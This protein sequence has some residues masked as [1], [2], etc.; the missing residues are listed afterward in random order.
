MP[1]ILKPV[2][3]IAFLACDWHAV[4]DRLA[5]L[6][7]S[8]GL[9]VY[10]CLYAILLGGLIAVSAIRVAAIRVPL[11]LLLAASAVFL[12]TYEWATGA[13]LDYVAFETMLAS[14]GDIGDAWAQHGDSLIK[15]LLAGG[16]LFAAIAL[17]PRETR[18]S[19][20]VLLAS[21]LA[22]LLILMAVFY[23]RGGEGGRALPAAFTPLAHAGL[24]GVMRVIDPVGERQQVQWP[25]PPV[26]P[27]GDIVL[28]V[29]ESIAAR[30][31]DIND[32]AGVRSGLAQPRAGLVIANFGVAASGNNC[33]AGSNAIL[34]YGGTRETFQAAARSWPS[35]WAY[36]HRAG[37]RTVYIDG[38]RSHGEL[39]NLMTPQEKAQIDSFEQM[40][41]VPLV[42]RDQRIADRIAGH[43]ANGVPEFIYVN[44]IGAH[45]P[46]ADKFPP[47]MAHY[48]PLPPHGPTSQTTDVRTA[49]GVRGSPEE[50]RLYRNAYRNTLEWNVGSFFDRLLAR[51]RPGQ[52]VLLYTS[53]HGQDLH[54]RGNPGQ[55][56]HCHADPLPEQGAVPLVVI[57]G[58]AAPRFDWA[59]AAAANRDSMSHFRL[60]A[61]TLALM[62]YDSRAIAPR[63]GPNLL[64]PRGEPLSFTDSYFATLGRKPAWKHI[65]PVRLASPP[66]G[67]SPAKP[68]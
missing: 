19:L 50:W 4:G 49:V 59:K 52:G 16:L 56:T 40:D 37:Y 31:L 26:K 30:Y 47:A 22:A 68:R 62:G 42:D 2:L 13:P 61:T 66:P 36:A 6:G 39:Q 46:V 55:T 17:P 20:P 1:R 41:G 23:L 54:E 60:I 10:L 18:R 15:A 43:L 29:D 58:A 45:F 11:G 67:D 7:L 53:D 21:P 3:L 57:D 32:P 12:L 24:H 33:S 8:P 35:L 9:A 51:F 38:Q 27:D 64:A 44:K 63:Y 34:R 65:D 14:S 48:T 25:A 28:I 5:S